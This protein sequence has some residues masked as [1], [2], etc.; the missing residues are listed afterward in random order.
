MHSLGFGKCIVSPIT[1]SYR[2]VPL[3]QNACTASIHPVPRPLETPKTTDLFTLLIVL[4]FTEFY[5]VE[6]IH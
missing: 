1:G 5:T 4:P 2:T 6:I 3:P